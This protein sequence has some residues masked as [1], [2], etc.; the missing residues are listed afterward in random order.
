[1]TNNQTFEE[2]EKKEKIK[3]SVTIED[4][5]TDVE[6][7]LASDKLHIM[8]DKSFKNE[9]NF[10]YSQGCYDTCKIVARILKNKYKFCMD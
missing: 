2:W 9:L 1:M 5:F 6:K 10:M 3:K 4:L 7:D 8:S